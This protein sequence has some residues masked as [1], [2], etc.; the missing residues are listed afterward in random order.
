MR[1]RLDPD[2][3]I[4]VIITWIS[5]ICLSMIRWCQRWLLSR[6]LIL[7]RVFEWSKRM[8]PSDHL[9]HR[10]Q[11][12]QLCLLGILTVQ[13]CTGVKTL[14]YRTKITSGVRMKKPQIWVNCYRSVGEYYLT[15][16]IILPVDCSQPED[17]EAPQFWCFLFLLDARLSGTPPLL[18]HYL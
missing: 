14:Y 17:F 2:H 3:L 5:P 7:D 1:L 18:P 11:C 8:V 12:S 13:Y 4:S 10:L 15:D 6:K 16:H 9:M